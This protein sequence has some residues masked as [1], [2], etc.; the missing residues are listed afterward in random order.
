MTPYVPALPRRPQG[1][2]VVLAVLFAVLITLL[3]PQAPGDGDSWVSVGS[4]SAGPAAVGMAPVAAAPVGAAYVSTAPVGSASVGSASVGPAPGGTAS[5]GSPG[6]AEA[7]PVY[8]DTLANHGDP[9]VTAAFVRNP[10]DAAGERQP[11]PAP[12]PGEPCGPAVDP[13]HP[14]RS[15]LSAA[16]PCGSGQPSHRHGVRAPPFLSGT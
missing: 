10:R 7:P 1:P 12:A 6:G 5:L 15:P 8:G 4:P 3:G 11:A 14:A 13:P 2:A 16:G 9:A